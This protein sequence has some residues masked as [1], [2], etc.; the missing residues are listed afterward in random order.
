MRK[1]GKHGIRSG[2]SMHFGSLLRHWKNEAMDEHV[3]VKTIVNHLEKGTPDHIY[4]SKISDELVRDGGRPQEWWKGNGRMEV[5]FSLNKH[6]RWLLPTL[7][8]NAVDELKYRV[9]NANDGNIRTTTTPATLS[10][11]YR[12]T[13]SERENN[14]R[15]ADQYGELSGKPFKNDNTAYHDSSIP[16]SHVI[17]RRNRSFY[18]DPREK[19]RGSSKN[20]DR[21]NE[22]VLHRP[23]KQS[24]RGVQRIKSTTKKPRKPTNM[25]WREWERS[26]LLYRNTKYFC[27]Y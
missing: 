11:T 23:Q 27:T 9:C 21:K 26:L 20:S 16:K 13:L 19:G 8:S 5:V 4:F 17:F 14:C 1:E 3:V 2:N 15:K 22:D 7:I 24:T 10:T 18:T 6:R 25:T 12:I